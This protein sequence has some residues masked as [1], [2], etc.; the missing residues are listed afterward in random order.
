MNKNI[1]FEQITLKILNQLKDGVLPWRKSWKVGIP[2]NYITRR[3]YNGINWLSLLL[4]EYGSPYYLTFLQCK[5][6]G[7]YVNQGEKGSLIVFF[8]LT[9]FGSN[10]E[11]L[12]MV[13][14]LRYSYSFNVM[15]TTIKIEQV[16][17][18]IISCEELISKFKVTPVIKNNIGR[19]Y[20]RIDEDYISLPSIGDFNTPEEYYSTLFHE[21]IHF[22]GA[23]KRL[24]RDMGK[25]THI[26][27][28]LVAEL[29]A[30]YLCGLCGISQSVIENQSAYINGWLKKCTDDK[31]LII[32]ASIEA[33]KAV[34]FL[35]GVNDR[36]TE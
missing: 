6:L 26:L 12:K 27:E 3:R 7:Q 2:Q 32:K 1:I 9:D 33:R 10:A 16:R 23:F 11:E 35:L 25:D 8:K 18:T 21:A 17:S 15:Q 19:A 34:D 30:S 13:P 36:N 14:L 20:Y 5:E 31:N 4:N 28:E 24:N 29:G 22:T